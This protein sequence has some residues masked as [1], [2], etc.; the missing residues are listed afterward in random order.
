MSAEALAR[1][2]AAL[3]V[4]DFATAALAT[5]EAANASETTVQGAA[6]YTA[7]AQVHATLAL[8]EAIRDALAPEADVAPVVEPP[9]PMEAASLWIPI[10]HDTVWSEGD[11]VSLV[12]GDAPVG[13]VVSA[14][15]D[16]FSDTVLRVKWILNAH[17]DTPW[18]EIP[19]ELL[20]L[21]KSDWPKYRRRAKADES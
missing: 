13:H 12:G 18:G 10:D 9:A 20:H 11:L 21:D 4:R 17:D 1:R 16:S 15:T 14:S 6:V 5:L 3:E 2:D 8:V 7:E 19:V